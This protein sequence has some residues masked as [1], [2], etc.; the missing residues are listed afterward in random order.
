ML[1]EHEFTKSTI[2]IRFNLLHRICPS[3]VLVTSKV[4]SLFLLILS[5]QHRARFFLKRLNNQNLSWVSKAWSPKTFQFYKSRIKSAATK[6]HHCMASLGKLMPL[7]TVTHPF[8]IYNYL[9]NTLILGGR[10]FEWS[11]SSVYQNR[12]LS[13]FR[14]AERIHPSTV[15]RGHFHE[16][17]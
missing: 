3:G 7:L 16:I 9:A 11:L 17:M 6:S 4:L 8:Y 10:L 13:H 2:A 15:Y 5:Q 12:V 1:G 14:F